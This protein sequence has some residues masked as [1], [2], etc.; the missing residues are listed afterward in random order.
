MILNDIAQVF[1]YDNPIRKKLE[2]EFKLRMIEE[3][4]R[5]GRDI[6]TTGSITRDNI[7]YYNSLI[8]LIRKENWKIFLVQFKANKEVLFDRVTHKS[9]G[10][11][12]NSVKKLQE[13]FKKY[14]ENLKK[15]GEG[16]QLVVDTT[17]LS[18]EESVQEIAKYIL[19]Q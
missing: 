19:S 18:P 7:H 6:I 4:A 12:I 13:F 14:P 15:F 9:R 11:K 2:F 10:E 3:S 1:G 16:K 8:E 17:K 5:E